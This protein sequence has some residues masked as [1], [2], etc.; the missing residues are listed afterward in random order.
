MYFT[1][2]I[3]FVESVCISYDDNEDRSRQLRQN[4][5]IISMFRNFCDIWLKQ[6]WYE[7]VGFIE[8]YK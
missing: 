4:G 3:S 8:K 6:F 7:I 2:G 5:N 1:C